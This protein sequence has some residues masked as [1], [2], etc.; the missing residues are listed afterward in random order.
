MPELGLQIYGSGALAFLVAAALA[1]GLAR[2]FSGFG[3]ALIFVP[4]ASAAVG[5]RL[6]APLLLVIDMIAAA[7]LLPG[8][9][10]RA[11]KR[12]VGLM[13]L[14]ALAGVPTGAWILSRT[15][16]LAVRW[17]IA[18]LTV[19]MLGL[20]MS[21]WR[22]R[23]RPRAPLTVGVGGI[24]GVLS[25]VAQV[26]GPP[27]VAYWLSGPNR[28]ETIRANIVL[29]FALSSVLAG[30][31]Y[32]GAGLMSSRLVGLMLL[33]APAYGVGLYAGTRA[34]GLA[35]EATFR[36]VCFG[37]IALAAL[38]SLPLLDELLR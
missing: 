15:D 31:S 34:F 27:V 19:A 13:T 33:T 25:G 11:D 18:A 24:S 14:G 23:D 12:A 32:W 3:A 37:L 26:G 30:L 10:R 29:Y 35:D 20:L 1:G 21:G 8:G 6:A 17:A 2:G 36:R 22:Y 5:P 4:L 7:P 38:L 16:P 28:P 9:W